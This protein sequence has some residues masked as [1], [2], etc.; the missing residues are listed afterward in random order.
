M[1]KKI[2]QFLVL[3]PALLLTSCLDIFKEKETS[4]SAYPTTVQWTL[5]LNQARF[6]KPVVLGAFY[7]TYAF[8]DN[9]MEV[10]KINI[11]K[12]E[13]CWRSEEHISNDEIGRAS[14][15]ERV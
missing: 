14:C 2:I 7:Y 15:R 6:S 9:G 4:E 5:L 8:T 10:V 12:G 11:E 13:I 3:I 1:R